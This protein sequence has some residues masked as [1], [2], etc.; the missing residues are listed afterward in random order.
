M[1]KFWGF[2]KPLQIIHIQFSKTQVS[3]MV[4]LEVFLGRL[5]RPLLKASLPLIII[6]KPLT[7]SVLI[8]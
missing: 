4:H 1:H 8:W 6:L 7:K 5:L 3:K 2:V